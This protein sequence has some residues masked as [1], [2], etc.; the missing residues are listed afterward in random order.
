MLFNLSAF[1]T[2]ILFINIAIAIMGEVFANLTE[3]GKERIKF[4]ST[5]KMMT[6]YIPLTAKGGDRERFTE[7]I[8]G[9]SE[10]FFNS[11]NFS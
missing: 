10:D 4:I 6:E 3:T 8:D 11:I 9:F 5:I 7:Y 1:L 2:A